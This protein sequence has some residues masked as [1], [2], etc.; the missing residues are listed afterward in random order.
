MFALPLEAKALFL[1]TPD[2]RPSDVISG[3][4]PKVNY[5]L[6]PLISHLD[7]HVLFLRT[8]TV[9]LCNTRLPVKTDTTDRAVSATAQSHVKQG[10]SVNRATTF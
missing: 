5:L 1:E 4:V 10:E 8:S 6:A 9:F 7:H 3:I 2:I